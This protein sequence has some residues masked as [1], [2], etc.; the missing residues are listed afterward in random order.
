MAAGDLA[1]LRSVEGRSPLTGGEVLLM[2]PRGVGARTVLRGIDAYAAGFDY[3]GRHVAAV[4]RDCARVRLLRQAVSAGGPASAPVRH[5]CRLALAKP[6]RLTR[7]GLRIVL[8][9]RGF[10]QF[11]APRRVVVRLRGPAGHVLGRRSGTV[12]GRTFTVPLSRAARRHLRTRRG[13]ALFISARVSDR[14]GEATTPRRGVRTRL[15][16]PRGG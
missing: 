12:G 7:R 10:E 16:R 13:V 5:K 8:S 15:A 2:S 6:P 11:C 9:C 3:D 4:G 14:P 1:V